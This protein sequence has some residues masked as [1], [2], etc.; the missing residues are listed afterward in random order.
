MGKL[1]NTANIRPW[2]NPAN[3]QKALKLATKDREAPGRGPLSLPSRVC[4]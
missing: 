3:Q 2:F 1:V 4:H